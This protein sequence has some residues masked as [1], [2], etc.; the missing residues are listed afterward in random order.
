MNL[1]ERFYR[2]HKKTGKHKF[3]CLYESLEKFPATTQE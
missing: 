3:V 1:F 2:Y